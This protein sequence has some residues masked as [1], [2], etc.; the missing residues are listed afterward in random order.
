MAARCHNRMLEAVEPRGYRYLVPFLYVPEAS[1]YAYVCDVRHG[2][3]G[4]HEAELFAVHY[5]VGADGE[6]VYEEG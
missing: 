1:A 4:F 3:V 2:S 5:A 6:G